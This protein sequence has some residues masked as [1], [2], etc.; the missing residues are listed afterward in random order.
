MGQAEP[1]PMGPIGP[2]GPRGPSGSWSTFN[3]SEKNELANMLKTFPELKGERGQTG[4]QGQP[5]AVNWGDLSEAQKQAM[6]KELK[7][8]DGYIKNETELRTQLQGRTMWCADGQ[9]CQ[10]PQLK[11]FGQINFTRGE[12]KSSAG[13]LTLGGETGFDLGQVNLSEQKFNSAINFTPNQKAIFFKPEAGG[14]NMLTLDGENNRIIF[15]D[16]VGNKNIMTISTAGATLNA[17]DLN[18]GTSGKLQLNTT[19]HISLGARTR[20]SHSAGRTILTGQNGLVIGSEENSNILKPIM[21]F[22][23]PK[24]TIMFTPSKTRLNSML[25]LDGAKNNILFRDATGIGKTLMTISTAGATLNAGD[26]NL[27]NNNANVRIRATTTSD[28]KLGVSSDIHFEVDGKE[29]L[30]IN[31]WGVNVWNSSKNSMYQV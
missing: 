4:K 12:L 23:Y 29:V 10:M 6:K 15:R 19:G 30:R 17:G 20:L 5:G 27:R 25:T 24:E 22:D 28:P 3:E 11:A 9:L 2:T 26:L 1:G 16:I 8:Q 31:K 14:K 18:L 13:R 21:T 7:G